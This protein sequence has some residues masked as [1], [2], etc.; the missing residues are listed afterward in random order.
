MKLWLHALGFVTTSVNLFNTH[1]DRGRCTLQLL[2]SC[3]QTTVLD[4][5]GKPKAA[6]LGHASSNETPDCTQQ[7]LHSCNFNSVTIDMSMT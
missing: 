5:T 4:H 7:T 2:Q 1:V 6:L 3:L